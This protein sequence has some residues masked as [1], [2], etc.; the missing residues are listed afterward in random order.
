MDVDLFI[1]TIQILEEKLI[2]SENKL[3]AFLDIKE[4]DMKKLEELKEEKKKKFK[5]KRNN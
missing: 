3:K 4:N 1:L 2:T 5:L